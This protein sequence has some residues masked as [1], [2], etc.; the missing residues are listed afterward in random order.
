MNPAGVAAIVHAAA[1]TRFNVDA[2]TARRVNV[3]GTARLLAFA[4]FCP[5][6][7]AV[8]LLS[9]IY[10][11]GLRPGLVEEAP[12]P[13]DAGFA[14][15]YE[16]SKWEAEQL[17]VGPF[18]R[19]PWRIFRIATVIA[20][21]DSG[22]V[23]QFNALHNTLK[24]WYH[25]LLSV[26]PGDQATPVYLLTGDFAAQAIVEVMANGPSQ[27][28]YHICHS[29]AESLALGG[30]IDVAF[31]AF[32]ESLE[33]RGRRIL[34]PLLCD[35]DSFAAFSDGMSCLGGPV[36]QAVSSIA[37][38]ARQLFIAKDVCNANLVAALPAYRA[39]D[40]HRL[41]RETCR[42]LVAGRWGKEVAALAR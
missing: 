8:G 5:S 19:L 21:D 17:L 12:L 24:L 31:D 9:T 37:P 35:A 26:L 30:L 41:V 3:E 16:S 34:R 36:G 42:Y 29:R 32:S 13:D 23:T 6:L 20:D 39:P 14:N 11:S 10:A 4:G 7:E 38:F 27:R 1:V 22:E 40:P 18:R 2:A 33:F 28:V 15:H 25:G